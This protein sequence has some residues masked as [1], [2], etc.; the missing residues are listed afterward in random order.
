MI[1][2][3]LSG[4]SISRVGSYGTKTSYKKSFTHPLYKCVSP[5]EGNYVMR[6]IHQGACGGHQGGRIIPGKALRTGYYWPTLK[7][8]AQDLVRR[9]PSCQIHSDI[10][11]TPATPLTT[12]Q[13]MLPFDKWGMDLLRPFS[14]ASGQR[15]F[16]IVAIDYFTK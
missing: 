3:R 11:R 9:G 5:E 6:E 7:S 10:P 16:S 12:I 13:V 2:K 1:Q 14:P 4:S 15:K 8:D